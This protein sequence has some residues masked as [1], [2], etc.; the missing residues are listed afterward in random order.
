MTP[1]LAHM[2]NINVHIH[3]KNSSAIKSQHVSHGSRLRFFLSGV[4]AHRRYFPIFLWASC[5]ALGH[6]QASCPSWEGCWLQTRQWLAAKK[7]CG[8]PW[9]CC[10][11]WRGVSSTS[12]LGHI[13]RLP[14]G[15]TIHSRGGGSAVLSLLACR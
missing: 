9:P 4:G 8:G 10:R 2:V 13:W 11:C 3:R 1:L 7:S 12:W 14:E 6:T 15:V 5:L